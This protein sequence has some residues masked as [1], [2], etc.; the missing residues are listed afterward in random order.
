MT[1]P[2]G[3]RLGSNYWKLWTASVVSNLGDGVA[4]VAYPWLASAITRSPVQIA[5]VGVAT[6]IPWLVFTL[7]AGVITDRVDRR[8][9]VVAMDVIRT[10]ITLGVAAVV[11]ANES[12]LPSPEELAG[13]NFA[14]V[15]SPGLLLGTLYVSALLL[16]MAEVL[17]DNSAQ[18]LMPSV[19]DK[20]L[21][22]RANGRLW[23]AEMV[24][25]AFVGPPL[26][27]FLLAVSFSLP[28]FVDGVTFAVSA[29]LIALMAGTF[30]TQ[31]DTA[32]PR[33]S[34]RADLKE[35]FRWLWNHRLLRRLAIV[36]GIINAVN[37]ASFAVIVL[38][39]QEILNLNASQ[40]GLLLS[41]GAA[42][43]V[44]GSLVASKFSQRFGPGAAIQFGLVSGAIT[45]AIIG[46]T[47]S[48]VV[49]WFMFA[50]GTLGGV[51]WNVVTVSLRQSIIPDRLLGRV[52]SV[53]RF[54]G[55][56]MM[57]IGA[58]LGGL[59]V[60]VV[61]NFSD[62]PTGLRAPFFVAAVIQV[63]LAIYAWSRINT[64]TMNAA[65]DEAAG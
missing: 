52:N 53:Y 16:G 5:L 19:V 63:G 9:L 62:R 46:W 22:E 34:F 7:P 41:S 25:N 23:G 24:M 4:G 47:S 58:F 10:F 14:T 17:R 30:R 65:R 18:T 31:V 1:T 28:F 12:V 11:L 27:G 26:A 42:G 48:A 8:R 32:A 64:R 59:L 51:I 38:F 40:F 13:G 29:A 33:Q 37:T 43:G 50:I 57:P 45:A 21:L 15:A 44:L 55:W 35:G 3:P 54:F 49:V 39:G 36:L 60:E 61:T 56:G 6:R 2:P 20:S